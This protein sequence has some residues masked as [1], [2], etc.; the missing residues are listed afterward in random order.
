MAETRRNGDTLGKLIGM[1]VFLLGIAIIGLSVFLA[2]QVFLDPLATL[3]RG[4]V[5]PRTT[6]QDLVGGFAA[7]LVR[8]AASLVLS[9][10]GSFIATRGI[11]LYEVARNSAAQGHPATG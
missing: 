4:T 6:V 11:R 3:P 5:G 2:Y 1:V 9:L 7:M 10:S 8:L